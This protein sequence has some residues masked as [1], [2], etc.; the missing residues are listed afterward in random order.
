MFSSIILD[1][2]EG[3]GAQVDLIWV[4]E[5]M[6]ERR[7]REKRGRILYWLKRGSG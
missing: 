5:C 2:R 7:G 6:E 4:I 3:R 1:Y